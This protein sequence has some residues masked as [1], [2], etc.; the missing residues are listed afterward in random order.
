MKT[1]EELEDWAAN[2]ARSFET[3]FVAGCHDGGADLHIP[4]FYRDETGSRADHGTDRLG[5]G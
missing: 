1:P 2:C 4:E 5:Q 3:T